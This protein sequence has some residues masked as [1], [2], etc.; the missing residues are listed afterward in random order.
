MIS[1][2]SQGFT[3]FTLIS[4]GFTP[5]TLISQGF[6]PF[7]LGCNPLPFQ[8]CLRKRFNIYGALVGAYT[9]TY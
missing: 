3:S 4:Q 6:T 1:M 9:G 5:F 7:T 2:I 8:G